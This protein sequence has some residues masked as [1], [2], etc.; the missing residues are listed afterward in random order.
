MIRQAE[1]KDLRGIAE[2]FIEAFPQSIAHFRGCRYPLDAVLMMFSVVL[3]ADPSSLSVFDDGGIILGYISAP[4]TTK[5][6]WRTA[7]V[8]LFR[9]PWVRLIRTRQIT[10]R[11]LGLAV[12]NKARFCLS[13]KGDV[14]VEPRILSLAVGP[15]WQGRGIGRRLLA[16]GLESLRQRGAQAVRL[17]VRPDNAAALALYRSFDF[18]E[19][20]TMKDSQ[21]SWLI[22]VKEME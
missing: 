22:M 14:P 16:A 20:G 21:G 7:A 8:Q 18:R 4:V 13:A 17:E 12:A 3:A 10:A 15:E 19:A 1:A 9:T 11:G 6:W 2:V 5:G